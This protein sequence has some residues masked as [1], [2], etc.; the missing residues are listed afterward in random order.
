MISETWQ[1]QHQQK[2][3]N[4]NHLFNIQ[5]SDYQNIL[6]DCSQQILCDFCSAVSVRK[7]KKKQNKIH[8]QEVSSSEVIS[9]FKLIRKKHTRIIQK[10]KLSIFECISKISADCLT[11]IFNVKKKKKW[12]QI[13][14]KQYLKKLTYLKRKIQM[15]K[16]LKKLEK[17]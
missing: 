8:C 16:K 13:E 11:D 2:S 5:F 3:E 7:R 12:N 15:M 17:S 9:N 14:Q 10:K 6:N 1:W 4:N